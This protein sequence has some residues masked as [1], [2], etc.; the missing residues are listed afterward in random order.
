MAACKS[1][2]VQT[3]ITKSIYARKT[4]SNALVNKQEK[5]QPNQ[6]PDAKQFTWI[7]YVCYNR[8]I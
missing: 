1:N 2:L 3:N 6:E 4:E 8:M 7:F 5:V